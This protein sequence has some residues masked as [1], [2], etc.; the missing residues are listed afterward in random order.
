MKFVAISDTHSRHQSLRLPKGD[1]LLHAGDITARGRKDE[2]ESFLKWFAAQPF[3]HKIFIG[4]NHDFFLEKAKPEEINALLPAGVTYLND[5]GTTI[6]E[7]RIW[8]SPVTPYFYGWAFNRQR[9]A[10]IR[11]HWE[12]IPP[13]IN[14]LITHGPAYGFLDTLNDEQHAGCPDLLRRVLTIC[15]SV[16]LCGHIHE[17]QGSI[18]RSGVQFINASVVNERYELANAPVVFSLPGAKVLLR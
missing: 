7:T 16:H 3:E 12:I 4:G 2:V 1:V 8:G 17:A 11:K 10:A 5:S 18:R 13:D 15:P 6:G 9:G 14:I